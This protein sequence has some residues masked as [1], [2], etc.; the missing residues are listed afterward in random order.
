MTSHSTYII[1]AAHRLTK[2]ASENIL[3][4]ERKL[5]GIT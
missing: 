1:K 3:F 2:F 5:T 4:E